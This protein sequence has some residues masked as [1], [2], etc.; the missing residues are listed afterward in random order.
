MLSHTRPLLNLAEAKVNTDVGTQAHKYTNL[1]IE[2]ILYHRS[3]PGKR[4]KKVP[5]KSKNVP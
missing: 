5:A 4:K 2:K 1:S 3:Q